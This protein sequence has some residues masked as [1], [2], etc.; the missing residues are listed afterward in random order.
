MCYK[1]PGSPFFALTENIYMDR[2]EKRTKLFIFTIKKEINYS[3]YNSGIRN[4]SCGEG[5]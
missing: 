1:C 3:I 4:K 5:T 2:I